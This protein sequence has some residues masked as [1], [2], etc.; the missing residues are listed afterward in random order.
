MLSI[1]VSGDRALFIH[2]KN[3]SIPI[4]F[5]PRKLNKNN[6]L[7]YPKKLLQEFL[8]IFLATEPII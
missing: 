6:P 2:S 3:L 5:I 1:F 8:F 7:L 4:I